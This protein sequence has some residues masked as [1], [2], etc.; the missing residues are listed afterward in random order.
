[1]SIYNK[2]ELKPKMSNNIPSYIHKKTNSLNFTSNSG[3]FLQENENKFNK[4]NLELKVNQNNNAETNIN[5]NINK[6]LTSTNIN[7][8]KIEI[9]L[10]KNYS[11]TTRLNKTKRNN[12]ILLK[13]KQSTSSNNINNNK[14]CN[15]IIN[16]NIDTNPNVKEKYGKNN[17]NNINININISKK[18][19]STTYYNKIKDKKNLIVVKNSMNSANNSESKDYQKN[20]FFKSNIIDNQNKYNLNQTQIQ[21]KSKND[22]NSNVHRNS[23]YINH[24][25][26]NEISKG[27]GR[28]N[29]Q[30]NNLNKLKKENKSM[31]LSQIQLPI[32]SSVSPRNVNNIQN[33]IRLNQ[34]KNNNSKNNRK[35][36]NNKS[37]NTKLS[38]NNINMYHNNTENNIND[39]ISETTYNVEESYN[40]YKKTGRNSPKK[41][42]YINRKSTSNNKNFDIDV[43]CPEELHF[44]YITIF[45]K[46]NKINFERKN[47]N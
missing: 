16:N 1:M 11:P 32:K 28:K 18:I 41:S 43:D 42:I 36:P 45:Q 2:P 47:N 34:G 23:G 19:I 25:E 14:N 17:N 35:S 3:R 5:Q 9:N 10:N 33:Y 40:T 30:D 22:L 31:F 21:N 6:L 37:N 8:K 26:S 27:N 7:N 39:K 12:I 38:S 4:K 20:K 15:I 29:N 24:T 13:H 46:G 44:F